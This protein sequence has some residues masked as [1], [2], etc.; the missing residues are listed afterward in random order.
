M[1]PKHARLIRSGITKAKLVIELLEPLG[2][3]GRGANYSP[4]SPHNK[5]A[6]RAYRHTWQTA[7]IRR[8]EHEGI[9]R[10]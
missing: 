6:A 1:R 4:L 2:S 9:H 5:L 7:E 8:D 10:P 3:W